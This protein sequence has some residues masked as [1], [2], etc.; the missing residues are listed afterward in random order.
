[1]ITSNNLYEQETG[2][3]TGPQQQDIMKSIP[4]NSTQKIVRFLQLEVQHD[5]SLQDIG[6]VGGGSINRCYQ[7]CGKQERY[8]VKT[9]LAS[10]ID[11]LRAESRGLGLLSGNKYLLVPEPITVGEMDGLALLVLPYLDLV[12][13]SEDGARLLGRG[14]AEQH[15]IENTVFGLEQDNY[16]G[17]TRQENR[18]EKDWIRFLRERRLAPQFA[19]AKSNGCDPSLVETGERLLLALPAF[20]EGYQPRP[21][22]LHGD[23]WAGNAAEAGGRPTIFD[24]A[25]YFGD[26]E[27]DIAMTELF[28][29]F[30]ETFYDV[31]QEAW[32]MDPGYENRKQLYNLYHVLNHFNLFG[33]GYAAQAERMTRTL[34]AWV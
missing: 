7:V 24:P 28:G 6:E 20:F 2:L 18:F 10:E 4:K 16:I 13:L 31:Y 25:V 21:S 15:R 29:R 1:L 12:S 34:L 11:N 3:G 19:K 17:L 30:P 22:L 23:L 5:F 26:R 9:N 14:L 32:P 8:F 33:G 27:T